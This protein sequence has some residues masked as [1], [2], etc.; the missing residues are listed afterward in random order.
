[1]SDGSQRSGV[2]GLAERRLPLWLAMSLLIAA[3]ASWAGSGVAARAAAGNVPPVTLAFLR[4]SIALL[5]FLPFGGLP[6]WRERRAFLQHWKTVV[7]FGFFGIVGF[8]T[9]YYV[10]LHFTT[11]VNSTILNATG[12][13]MV[14][15]LSFAM[16]GVVI[17]RRQLAG[18]GLALI[19]ALVIVARGDLDRLA[20]FAFNLGDGLVLAAYLSW[21]MYTV[22]LRW[23]PQGLSQY[24]FLVAMIGVSCLMLA[25]GF[26][27]ELARGMT[28]E[29]TGGNLLIVGYSAVVASV[30]AYLF[31]NMAVPVLGANRAA[32]SLYLQPAFGVIFGI[33]ILGEAVEPFHFVGV[34]AIFAGVYLST[35]RQ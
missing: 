3:S 11:V 4:W 12:P 15:F 16:L 17:A 25:P 35:A 2:L 13:I 6:L 1:M 19:G 8:T 21:S 7:A 30:V 14:V 33:V 5:L 24:S 10:G 32:V 9:P 31:W 29:P 18:I 23:R 34:I 28:F 20:A 26:A 22:M 27:W